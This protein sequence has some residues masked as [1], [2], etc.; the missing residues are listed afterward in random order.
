[1]LADSSNYTK[2]RKQNIQYIV[3][4]YTANNGDR[5]ES[6][7]KYF[8]QPNR[9]ASAHYFVDES[10]VVQSVRDSDTAWHCGAKSYKH[11]KCRNDN[12]IGVEMCSEKDR[13]GQYYINE[14]TQNMIV[15]RTLQAAIDEKL[16]LQDAEKN[17]IT[18]SD[19]DIEQS[20]KF[21]ETSNKIPA[22]KLK[23]I[24]KENGVNY[25]VFLEQMKSDLAWIRII[26]KLSYAE[27]E[28]TEKEIETAQKE[29]DKDLSTPKYM[30]SEILIK[31]KNAK[32]LDVL[33]SNLRQDPRFDLYAMQFSEAPS[34]SKGGNLGWINK[35]RL[36]APLKKALG[37][38]K[39][40]EVS[41]P[42][43]VGQDYYILKLERIFD[44]KKD[45]A[46]TPT[47]ENIKKFLEER[48]MEELAAKHLQELRQASV[49]EV[50]M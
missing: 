37:K 45:K 44:P 35:E 24:L 34:S 23:Q 12:S 29:A 36:I 19:K 48:R 33:V 16:K 6:N 1:M 42:I 7:G 4:H 32:N 22:G 10:N 47:K 18:I 17:G 13:K 15:Q 9:N 41:D 3:V 40:G 8:Q 46:E 38:L 25:D 30:V 2:G 50:R 21:F 5:A 28:L 26:R 39:A 20:V 43:K 27:G 14:Q 11:D 49:V 31:N